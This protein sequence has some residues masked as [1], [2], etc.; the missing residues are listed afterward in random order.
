[1]KC[2]FPES[3]YITSWN[4]TWQLSKIARTFICL[5]IHFVIRYMDV[6]SMYD[7]N[8]IGF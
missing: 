8:G 4:L 5:V 6:S 1:M 2:L 7:V 3:E